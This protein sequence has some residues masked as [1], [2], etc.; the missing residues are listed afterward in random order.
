MQKFTTYITESLN[1]SKFKN[2]DALNEAKKEDAMKVVLLSN[3]SSSSYS[4]KEFEK[5]FKRKG[6]DY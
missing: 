1:S 6:I 4:I 3:M 5:E 2:T